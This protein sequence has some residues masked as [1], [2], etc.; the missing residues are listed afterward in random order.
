MY[1]TSVFPAAGRG[2]FAAA[3][4][5][6]RIHDERNAP[7]SPHHRLHGV[8]VLLEVEELAGRWDRVVELEGRAEASVRS[9]LETP[10]IRNARSLYVCAL[11]RSYRGEEEQAGRLEEHAN[12]VALE[13]YGLTID[14]LRIRLGLSRGDLGEVE[15]LVGGEHTVPQVFH[16]ESQAGL[17]DGLA[18]LRDRRTEAEA[19][20]LLKPNTYLEPF[21]LRALGLVREDERLVERAIARFE[22][23]GLD[24]YARQTRELVAQA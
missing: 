7:L 19:E 3:R 10:C 4:R 2:D 6:A 16:L 13:G 15:R 12:E 20:P 23:M 8:S 1:F 5:F 11:A 17:L 18:V 22:A 24:W 9:N 14:A 21:A